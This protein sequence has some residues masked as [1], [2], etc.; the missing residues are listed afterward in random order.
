MF[1]EKETFAPMFDSE[2]VVC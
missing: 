1:V 2:G